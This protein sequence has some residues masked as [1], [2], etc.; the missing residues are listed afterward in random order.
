MRFGLNTTRAPND[1][2]HTAQQESCRED[3]LRAAGPLRVRAWSRRRA[4]APHRHLEAMPLVRRSRQPRSVAAPSRSP[5]CWRRTRVREISLA[6]TL[7]VPRAA[8]SR[9]CRADS[10][11]LAG[12]LSTA[13]RVVETPGAIGGK[14]FFD[15]ASLTDAL[16]RAPAIGR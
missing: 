16:R 4:S 7:F 2:V 15:H 5:K 10:S 6:Q 12:L 9:S 1:R 8:T 14:P 3:P 11:F 13:R